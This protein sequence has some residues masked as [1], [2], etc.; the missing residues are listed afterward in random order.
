MS[1][2]FDIVFGPD[3][4]FV[5]T[6]RGEDFL[7]FWS[8][9]FEDTF[10]AVLRSSSTKRCMAYAGAQNWF[11]GLEGGRWK[12]RGHR[13]FM[14]LLKSVHGAQWISLGPG[15]SYIFQDGQGCLRWW[16]IPES[17]DVAI[18]KNSCRLLWATLGQENSYVAGFA[19]GTYV[20]EGVP[21]HLD[22]LLR[23]GKI[24]E[25]HSLSSVDRVWLSALDDRYY[26]EYNGRSSQWSSCGEYFDAM[27]SCDAILRPEDVWYTDDTILANFIDGGSIYDTA[28]DLNNGSL[29]I[30]DLPF[31]EVF[32][33]GTGYFCKNN[34]RLWCFRNSGVLSIPVKLVAP[35][36]GAMALRPCSEVHISFGSLG[37][38]A[39]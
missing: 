13:D 22:N 24:S 27:M 9:S 31:V 20:W 10:E 18:Q 29:D 23:T 32:C 34:R 26:M 16:N 7:T 3:E 14:A 39:G 36:A 37:P 15:S 21:S 28:R 2:L 33:T 38:P 17:L 6:P 30:T 1:D 12:A 11:V 25:K 35:P 4:S 19:D 8:G 5:V